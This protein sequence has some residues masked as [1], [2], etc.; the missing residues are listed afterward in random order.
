MAPGF[1]RSAAWRNMKGHIVKLRSTSVLLAALLLAACN[2]TP[3]NPAAVSDATVNK[4]GD[5]GKTPG[6]NPEGGITTVAHVDP[7]PPGS[8]PGAKA[9]AERSVYFDY[10]SFEILPAGR[11]VVSAQ[12][13]YLHDH[14]EAQVRLEGNADE[15]GGSEYNL[16]LGQK[17]A[18]AV[19]RAMSLLGV[20]EKQ[21][22]AVSFGKEKPVGLGHDEESWAKNRRVDVSYQ[23]R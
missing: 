2:S 16:A 8:D 19:R 17:R 6:S 12:S 1:G 18:E 15:R 23:G 13:K 7:T 3:L 10:N 11:G 5:A 4:S 21:M 20:P 22:E 14:P 9:P